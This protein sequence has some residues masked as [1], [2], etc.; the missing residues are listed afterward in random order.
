MGRWREYIAISTFRNWES[1]P[2]GLAPRP[3]HAFV[4]VTLHMPPSPPKLTPAKI[5]APTQTIPA[6]NIPCHIRNIPI[7]SDPK[8]EL[9]LSMIENNRLY[10]LA[11]S[12]AG[13]NSA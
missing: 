5:P 4:N 7:V 3:P 8:N 10:H 12:P 6:K 9:L 11:S 1:R 13:I 2:Q